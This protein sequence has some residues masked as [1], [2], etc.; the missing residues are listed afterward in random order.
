MRID[1]NP[2][3]TSAS[4]EDALKRR[5]ECELL[6]EYPILIGKSNEISDIRNQIE[7]IAAKDITVLITGESGTGKELIARSIHCNSGRKGEAFV[8]INCGALPDELLE[9][10]VFGYQRGAFTG[11]HKDKPGR[12]ELADGGTLFIDEIGVLSLPLPV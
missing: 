6:P 2:D 1:E 4:I 8:K 9:S 12:V 3:T 11:A 7:K 10:E 5:T